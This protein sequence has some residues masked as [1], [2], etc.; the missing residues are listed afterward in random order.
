MNYSKEFVRLDKS[1]HDRVTFDCGEAELNEFIQRHAAR[2][3]DA[4]VSTTMVMPAIDPSPNGKYPIC[5][6]YT[7]APSSI[8]RESLPDSLR[9][10]LPY[11]PVPVF[12]I[13]Q[14][15]V[16]SD[17]QGLGLGKITLVKALE[18]LLNINKH[19]SAYAIIVDCLNEGVEK[20]YSKYGFEI[21]EYKANRPR[22]FIPMRVVEQLF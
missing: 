15:A 12:L 16:H 11:Y 6:F 2:H 5:A 18:Y 8:E 20:F 13:A 7:I 1:I 17:C 19:M 14:M 21:L 10:E 9:K 22:M 4:G 3:M